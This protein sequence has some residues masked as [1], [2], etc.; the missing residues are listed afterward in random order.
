MCEILTHNIYVS[1][2]G[3]IGEPESEVVRLSVVATSFS[4]GW[5]SAGVDWLLLRDLI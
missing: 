5:F 3:P 4:R 2:S 1:I